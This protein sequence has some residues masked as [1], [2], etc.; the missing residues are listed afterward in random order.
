MA[1]TVG[2]SARDR[3]ASGDRQR[4]QQV[5]LNLIKNAVEAVEGAGDVAS[6]PRGMLSGSGVPGQPAS[7]SS[8]GHCEHAVERWSRSRCGTTVP[9]SRRKIVPRIFDP[10]FTTK[11]VG[12]GSGLGLFIVYEII[13]EHGGC[14]AVDSQPGKGHDFHDPAAA[15][16]KH[17]EETAAP[18]AN[19]RED[20]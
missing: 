14:I 3:R 15:S 7:L 6:P 18:M 2:H 1:V 19:R 13:E 4:L 12:K 16:T 11:D 5:F 20:C 17:S 9:A 10:F 8:F